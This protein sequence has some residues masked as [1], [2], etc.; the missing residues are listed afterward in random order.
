MN[1][2]LMSLFLFLC[3]ST[4]GFAVTE[5]ERD[6]LIAIYN[7]TDGANWG[8]NTDWNTTSDPCSWF[9]VSCDDNDNVITLGLT[10]NNLTGSIPVEIENL[11]YLLKLDLSY[12]NLIGDIPPEIEKLSELE[13]LYL[14]ANKLTG[15]I[16]REIGSL[17]LLREID[18]EWNRFEG[19]I[20]TELGDLENL[21]FLDF[22]DNNLIGTIPESFIALTQL[23]YLSLDLNHLSGTI[24]KDIIDLT[25]LE[26]DGGLYLNN[27]YCLR[28]NDSSVRDFIVVK[29]KVASYDE[30]L[31]THEDCNV[32]LVPIITYILN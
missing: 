22:A 9:G 29:S 17:S 26:D 30:F 32:S 12:N 27:N 11:S 5:S 8:T 4:E 16:P 2:V 21:I 13:V 20:P 19:S 25:S 14:N 23:A 15:T 6:G 31:A 18:L 10:E 7:N 3:I 24:P 28:S 1:K